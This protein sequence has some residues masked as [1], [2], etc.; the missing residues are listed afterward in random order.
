MK[1]LFVEGKYG[2]TI[3]FFEENGII[4]YKCHRDHCTFYS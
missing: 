4:I 1:S 2:E 3:E